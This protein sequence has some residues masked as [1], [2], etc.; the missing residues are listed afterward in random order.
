[1]T[2]KERRLINTTPRMD[3]DTRAGITR[4]IEE[5]GQEEA[6][7]EVTHLRSLYKEAGRS[8]KLIEY[9]VAGQYLLTREGTLCKIIDEVP[10]KSRLPQVVIV[11]DFLEITKIEPYRTVECSFE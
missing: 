2:E 1:M 3:F 7:K 4:K 6:L 11:D 10:N 9:I 8:D 5:K